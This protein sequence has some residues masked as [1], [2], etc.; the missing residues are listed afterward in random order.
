MTIDLVPA[1]TMF[2]PRI[3]PVDLRV[4]RIFELAQYRVRG[5]FDVANR[6]NANGVHNVQRA[7]GPSYLNAIQIM[8][9]R[10]MK[11]G[12]PLDF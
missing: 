7:Y 11:V 4:S 1:G 5:N 10:L 12:V 6:F 9:G 8:G 2:E 3:Q